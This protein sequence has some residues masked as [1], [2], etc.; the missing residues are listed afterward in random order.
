MSDDL[1]IKLKPCDVNKGR[2]SNGQN[3]S[4]KNTESVTACTGRL[5]DKRV[6]KIGA[7]NEDMYGIGYLN[8]AF[9]DKQCSG[10]SII[11]TSTSIETTPKS[12]P[13]VVPMRSRKSST[14]LEKVKDG[15]VDVS[16][17]ARRKLDMS[18]IPDVVQTSQPQAIQA[19]AETP[20]PSSSHS[21]D[22]SE[23][24]FHDE[25]EE[26][27]LSK[28]SKL[29]SQVSSNTLIPTETTSDD[30]SAMRGTSTSFTHSRTNPFHVVAIREMEIVKSVALA[31]NHVVLPI[32]NVSVEQMPQVVERVEIIEDTET[33]PES[34]DDDSE[35][36]INPKKQS[37]PALLKRDTFAPSPPRNTKKLTLRLTDDLAKKHPYPLQIQNRVR[38]NVLQQC[39]RKIVNTR[40]NLKSGSTALRTVGPINQIDP[41]NFTRWKDCESIDEYLILDDR[42]PRPSS[43]ENPGDNGPK[44]IGRNAVASVQA[45]RVDNLPKDQLDTNAATST[46]PIRSLSATKRTKFST[47]DDTIEDCESFYGSDKETDDPLIFSDDTEIDVCSSS[48]S[49]EDDNDI[50]LTEQVHLLD[51]V[52][53]K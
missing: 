53:E 16:R 9:D 14:K 3:D 22:R 49:G 17:N 42:K 1:S 50:K 43:L 30:V 15:V 44:N 12:S 6:N 7:M 19:Q 39:T 52:T 34:I 40:A 48:S 41:M 38:R 35:D 20:S 26:F 45:T 13:I 11:T 18:S 24:M 27:F 10:R 4:Y 51:K 8:P 25:D 5:S 47:S 36:T 29:F 33:E 31:N 21:P 23:L 32:A 2:D 28:N 46:I 37:M